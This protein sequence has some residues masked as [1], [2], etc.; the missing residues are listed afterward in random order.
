MDLPVKLAVCFLVLG[1]MTPLVLDAAQDAD[2]EMGMHGLREDARM[3]ADGIRDAYY[4]GGMVSVEMDLPPGQSI[5]AGGG[6][7]DAYCLRLCQDGEAVERLH[8]ENPVV[9]ISGDAVV[10]SGSATVGLRA[11]TDARGYCVELMV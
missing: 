11:C 3:L 6:G 9:R 7:A 2:E 5:E 10:I 4:G 1:L 8:L